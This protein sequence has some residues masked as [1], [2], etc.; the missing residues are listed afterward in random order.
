MKD[1]QT[2]VYIEFTASETTKFDCK[3]CLFTIYLN[4][5]VYNGSNMV[6][7]VVYW[8]TKYM[9]KHKKKSKFLS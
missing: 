5:L 1:Y 7:I 9:D 2:I 8:S 4:K 6:V 3:K